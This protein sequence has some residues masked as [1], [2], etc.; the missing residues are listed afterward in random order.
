MPCN[1]HIVKIGD[2]VR[3][4]AH[5]EFDMAE[6]GNA[7]RSVVKT[8]VD[9]GIDNA[10]LDVRSSYGNVTVGQLHQLTN[11]FHELGFRERHHLAVLHRYRG[12]EKAELFAIFAESRGWNVRAFDLF[13][14]AIEW[15]SEE[16]PV[17]DRPK[18]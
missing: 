9:R 5:G 3:L 16:Q 15:F 2:F 8:C 10:L 13:E 7:L 4:N 12:G 17:R 14:D 11:I 6:S 1:L 18:Q